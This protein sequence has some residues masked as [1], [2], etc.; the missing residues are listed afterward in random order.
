MFFLSFR[1][2]KVCDR[3]NVVEKRGW[4]QWPHCRATDYPK[5]CPRAWISNDTVLEMFFG[6]QDVDPLWRELDTW[7]ASFWRATQESPSDFRFNRCEDRVRMALVPSWR[8]KLQGFL[9]NGC[10]LT[11]PTYGKGI[12]SFQ[13]FPTTLQ[14]GHVCSQEG[15]LFCRCGDWKIL[16]WKSTVK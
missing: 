4:T 10:S 12:L 6:F 13:I 3:V 2:H 9:K 8:I 7:T 14:R 16:D 15:T 11:H 1:C 5:K